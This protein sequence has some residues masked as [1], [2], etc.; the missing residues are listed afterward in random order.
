MKKITRT[1]RHILELV[2]G[3]IIFVAGGLGIR[4]LLHRRSAIG[5]ASTAQLIKSDE[6]R[7]GTIVYTNKG[8]SPVTLTVK[9]GS[10]VTIKN[11]SSAI[12]QFSSDSRAGYANEPE[13]NLVEQVPGQSESFK[14]TKVGRWMY[15]NYINHLQ[16]GMLVVVS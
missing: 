14:P 6:A 1:H 12:L 3:G 16:T 7:P 11:D 10:V 15:Y 5:T 8:F 4:A 9:E 13:L 2:I